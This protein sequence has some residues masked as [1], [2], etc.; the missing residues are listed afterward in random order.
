MLKLSC[1]GCSKLL[2]ITDFEQKRNGMYYK[3]CKPCRKYHTE[4][5]KAKYI[6]KKPSLYDTN[7]ELKE[8]WNESKNGSM[9]LYTQYSSKKVWWICSK[10]T[11]K[12][13]GKPHEWESRIRD[14][15]RINGR[16][17]GCPYCSIPCKKL[18]FCGCNSLYSSN[19]EL[20]NEWNEDKNGSMKLY[21]PNSGKKVWWICSKG[22][23]QTTGNPHEWESMID[24][25]T[26]EKNCGCP[27][28]HQR[29]CPCGCNSL[30]SS[31]PGLQV[32]WN[33]NKNGSMKLYS[34]RNGKKA[35]WICSKGICKTTGNSHEW[36]TIISHRT[37]K[38]NL[39]CPY[40]S[41]QKICSCGCNSLF[42]SH[43]ELRNEWNE[44][45][46]GNM[47]YYSAGSSKKVWWI[48]GKGICK[49]TE[50]S[51]EWESVI[52]SRTRKDQT[53]CP[54]C[55]NKKICS[56]GCNS[57]Y[58]SNPELKEE[59]NED[60]NGSM[61]LYAPNSNK[62]VWWMCKISDKHKWISTIGHRTVDKTGCPSCNQSKMETKITQICSA[63]SVDHI[64]QKVH[65]IQ[66]R[67]LKFDHFLPQNNTY[68]ECQGEQHWYSIPYFTKKT[69]FADQLRRDFSKIKFV[70]ENKHSFLSISYLTSKNSFERILTEFLYKLRDN[71]REP[72][73][74]FYYDE[75][76]FWEL[77]GNGKQTPVFENEPK[78]K[79]VFDIYNMQ[80]ETLS[81]D[82][83][84]IVAG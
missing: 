19:P 36:K 20:R 33:E 45:K 2:V 31:N 63:M 44:S 15:Y 25:R 54:Y 49:T 1:Q 47:K 24:S 60:K 27:Y 64:G 56:C 32:E 13:T 22:V 46:N 11:C 58:S 61:Q 83:I 41:N 40:C 42:S 37:G 7:L 70:F 72:L 17:T 62:K 67:N 34:S 23:C 28:C 38:R 66:N 51:H 4:I 80:Y 16:K 84:C 8:G 48:C 55:S 57:L 9:Q 26:G 12:T 43:P 50:N 52:N 35:W 78:E 29:V 65:T 73:Y 79:I 6:K 77:H 82:C 10:G 75:N 68:I 30:Y 21:T 74:R 71:P 39:G 59:W 5:E 14:R 18:C 69:S 3:R 53:G 81:D 76:H